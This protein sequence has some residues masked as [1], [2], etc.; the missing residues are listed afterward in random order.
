MISLV[1]YY[2]TSENFYDQFIQTT[3]IFL[4]VTTIGFIYHFF[5]DG[6]LIHKEKEY[7]IPDD[8]K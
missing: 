5:K 4:V 1:G 7:N 6:N 8:H 3:I 2:L